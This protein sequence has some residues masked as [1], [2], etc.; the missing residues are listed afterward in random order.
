MSAPA[1]TERA[2][3]LRIAP[4]G[5]SFLKLD[6]LGATNGAYLCLKRISKKNPLKAAP[7]LFDTADIQVETA[8]QGNTRFVSEYQLI[9]RR[10]TIGR[11]YRS[12]RHASE[13]CAF[14]A[15]NT[16]HMDDSTEIYNLAERTLD[17]F[18]EHSAPEIVLLKGI[19]LLLKDEGY[20]VRESWW[21]QVPAHLREPAKSILNSPSPNQANPQILEGCEQTTRH[22]CNWLRRETDLMLPDSLKD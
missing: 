8:K 1:T 19:Y 15:Q 18:A 17:A 2:I 6:V 16:P 7:D 11:S 5:E 22:L 20:P 14:L 12:L 9:R 10:D 13:F 21:P 4:S 3:I